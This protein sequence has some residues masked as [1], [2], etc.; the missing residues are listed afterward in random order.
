[1]TLLNR[2]LWW[3]RRKVTDELHR[4]EMATDASFVRGTNT[5]LS[6]TDFNNIHI[7][8]STWNL[9][10]G[11]TVTYSQ[12]RG[13]L[14]VKS[15]C[16]DLLSSISYNPLPSEPIRNSVH[17]DLSPWSKTIASGYHW[18]SNFDLQGVC[19]CV[20]GGG[21]GGWNSPCEFFPD[22][23][24][25]TRPPPPCHHHLGNPKCGW[26][27]FGWPTRKCEIQSTFLKSLILVMLCWS[28]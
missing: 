16:W 7:F 25:P 18:P 19:V 3:G 4:K 17:L 21:G 6:C 12:R 13:N 2:S 26:V 15:L 27:V 24:H 5:I 10:G 28:A 23:P 11:P 1:M 8:L 9:P 22:T 14:C 20:C